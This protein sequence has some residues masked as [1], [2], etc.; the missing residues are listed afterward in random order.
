MTFDSYRDS[1]IAADNDFIDIRAVPRSSSMFDDRV[2]N[3]DYGS[4]SKENSFIIP[5]D[6]KKEVNTILK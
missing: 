1:E 4:G 6:V 5:S 2:K 3:I